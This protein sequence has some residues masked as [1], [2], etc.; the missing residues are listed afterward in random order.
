MTDPGVLGS[1]ALVITAATVE[2]A[3][4]PALSVVVSVTLNV[5][6]LLKTCEVVGDEELVV[7]VPSPHC[8][9]YCVIHPFG[10]VEF[11]PSKLTG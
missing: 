11:T 9:E 1:A 4:A 3:V 7:L 8:H 5:P 6:V 10:D 2:E